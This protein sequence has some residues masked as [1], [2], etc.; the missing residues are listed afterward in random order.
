M[1]ED[2]HL[3]YI[4]RNGKLDLETDDG[5]RLSGRVGRAPLDDWDL[6]IDDVRRQGEVVLRGS[7]SLQERQAE[8]ARLWC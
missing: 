6:D 3:D 4:E 2:K 8:A 5:E 7:A 1:H